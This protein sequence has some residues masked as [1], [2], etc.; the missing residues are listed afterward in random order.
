M[1]IVSI[2]VMKRSQYL[3]NKAPA[4]VGGIFGIISSLT[5]F[6]GWIAILCVPNY[7]NY[8]N[9]VIVYIICAPMALTF[10]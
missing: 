6:G 10:W 3:T 9:K 1:M 5:A 8:D 7:P 2:F 4:M